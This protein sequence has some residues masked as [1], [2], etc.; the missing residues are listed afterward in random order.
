MH[1][2]HLYGTGDWGGSPTEE[3]VKNVDESVRANKDNK[4]FQV[5]SARSDKVFTKL[6]RY[7]NGANGVFIPR[8]KGDMLM[9]N[10]GAGC[11]TSPCVHISH[12]RRAKDLIIKANK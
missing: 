1:I 2:N 9:T 12:V 5:I 10:H 4:L 3:S 8:Y 11:Y 6:K 7:N